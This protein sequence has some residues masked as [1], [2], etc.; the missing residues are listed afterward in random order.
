M[1]NEIGLACRHEFGKNLEFLQ[2]SEERSQRLIFKHTFFNIF[3][4]FVGKVCFVYFLEFGNQP[5]N[6]IH[7]LLSEDEVYID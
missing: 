4:K 5:I 7:G 2:K 6:V 3:V 1:I